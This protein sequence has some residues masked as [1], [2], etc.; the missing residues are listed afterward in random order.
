MRPPEDIS[1]L[2]LEQLKKNSSPMEAEYLAYLT[3][4]SIRQVMN[5]AHQLQELELV[6]IND[7]LI[8][9]KEL[10]GSKFSNWDKLKK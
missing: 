7:M 10:P 1:K 4:S 2:L 3:G 8:K 9:L 5:A 6:E